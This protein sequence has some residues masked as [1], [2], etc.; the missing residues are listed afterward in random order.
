MRPLGAYATLLLF[1]AGDFEHHLPKDYLLTR[2]RP[3]LQ[4]EGAMHASGEML[5]LPCIG[6]VVVDNQLDLRSH[7]SAN[8][9]ERV[10]HPVRPP[11][12]Q[13][14]TRI[15]NPQGAQQIQRPHQWQFL[16]TR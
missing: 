16:H 2:D 4:S 11:I 9:S 12:P 13:H 1:R 7:G 14:R 5:D 15:C 3:T 6:H 10:A 8:V